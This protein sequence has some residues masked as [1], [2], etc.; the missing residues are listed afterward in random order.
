MKTIIFYATKYGTTAEIA[1][2]IADR[3]DGATVHD[4]KNNSIPELTEFDCVIIGS[5]LYVGSIRK[6]A[7][8]FLAR[9]EEALQGKSVGLFL[10]GMD[11]EYT[12]QTYF[13]KN[14]KQELVA[15]AKA[16]CFP[17]GIYDPEKA[18]WFDRFLMKAAKKSTVYSDTIDDS[19]I[20]QFVEAMKLTW[21]QL[22]ERN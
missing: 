11:T 19:K 4:L 20:E 15:A 10:S 2:R 8:S 17:G 16:T 12:P 21:E 9:N 14:F 3:I 18:G 7:K 22:N 5:S 13:E 6:E 1:K